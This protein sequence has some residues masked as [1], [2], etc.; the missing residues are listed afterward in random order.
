MS[1]VDRAKN[2]VLSPKTEWPVIDGEATT[3]GSLYSGYIVPLAL[4]GPIAGWI[5]MSVFGLRIPFTGTTIRMPMGT[6]LGQA[7]LRFVLALISVYILALIIDALAPSFGGTKNML[8]ALKVSAYSS[9]AAWLA[10]IFG[11]FP[12]I[13]WLAI[14]G[15]WSLYLLYTGLPVLMKSPPEKSLGYT[16]VVIIAAI[17]LFILVGMIVGAAFGMGR[18]MSGGL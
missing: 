13:S 3:V 12:A 5:G 8:Q 4:I 1:L 2:I 9:T 7:V 15:L 6:G 14:L 16:L 18:M 17:V 11:I 10:G